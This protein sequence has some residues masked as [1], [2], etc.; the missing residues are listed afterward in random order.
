MSYIPED[1]HLE[2]SPFGKK[3]NTF[4]LFHNRIVFQT[5]HENSLERQKPYMT[6][7]LKPDPSVL[8]LLFDSGW[9]LFTGV[10]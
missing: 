6:K 1:G 7:S 4:P 10:P 2:P 8:S 9:R 5:Q 3:V